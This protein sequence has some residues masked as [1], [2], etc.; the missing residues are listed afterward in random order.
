M[1]NVLLCVCAGLLGMLWALDLHAAGAV[2]VEHGVVYANEGEFA[3]WPA[4][5]GFWQWGNEMLVG[6]NVTQIKQ[7]DD[8]HNID[9]NTYMW[10]N[11]ARS[12]NGGK[13]W[14]IEEHPEI[15][16][17]GGLDEA[18]VYKKKLGYPAIK[19]AID[20]G[21]GISFTDDS[22]GMKMRWNKFWVTKDRGR[23]WQ[24]PYHLPSFG[25]NR[26]M[27]RT[28]YVVIDSQT[29]LLFYSVTNMPRE[30]GEHGRTLVVKT[31]DGGKT[32]ENLGWLTE[33]PYKGYEKLKGGVL[34]AYALM[35]GV[36][37]LDDG[38]VLAAVRGRINRHKW[39]DVVA[40]DD[41]GKTWRKISQLFDKNNNPASLV[42]LGGQRIAAIY[43]YRGEPYGIRAKVSEDG[44]VTWSR[45]VMLRDDGREWD[46]GYV[47]AGLRSDGRITAVY[48]HTTESHP[49]EFIAST[50]WTVDGAAAPDKD[51][52][53]KKKQLEMVAH[54]TFEDAD[55]FVDDQIGIA[56]GNVGEG[57]ELVKKMGSD[58]VDGYIAKFSGENC[59]GIHLGEDVPSLQLGRD[60]FVVTGRFRVPMNVGPNMMLIE[61][62]HGGGGFAAFIGRA[63][64]TYRGRLMF[65]V[66]GPGREN[67]VTLKSDH[68]VDDGKWHR[69]ELI[70]K[71]GE[72]RMRVDG[73]LQKGR[74]EY[75]HGTT[76]SAPRGV[77]AI[78]GRGLKGELDELIVRQ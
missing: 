42:S 9:K 13:T 47:R 22:F 75:G 55:G 50:I 70:V 74:T 53:L 30:K 49:A 71:D 59:A 23:V 72:M 38:T 19:K 40:S 20:Y 62:Q 48:Y 60:D 52:Q 61:S 2:D 27:A 16:T 36:M 21:G 44:G 45:E 32:F 8:F 12:L 77:E 51:A 34:P 58:A 73:K 5:E 56:H 6:F 57:V 1:K 63:D 37:K 28:N 78:I 33:D 54:W 65:T 7:R 69:F 67:D 24:G 35:P 64:R 31:S 4:N 15:S 46:L 29:M 18:G 17:P 66:N 68:R 25:F 76:A 39:V 11:F 26:L 41:E 3:G 43:G 14:A 10:I